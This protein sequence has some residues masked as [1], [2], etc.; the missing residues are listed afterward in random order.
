MF[1]AAAFNI[2][3]NSGKLVQMLPSLPLLIVGDIHGDIIS[4]F[5]VLRKYIA[6]LRKNPQTVLVFL[7]DYVDRG[8]ASIDILIILCLIKSKFPSRIYLCRGNHETVNIH[9]SNTND[10]IVYDMVDR[11]TTKA[12]KTFIAFAA[13]V[14]SL[15]FVFKTD[16]VICMHGGIDK[17][18]FESPVT[19]LDTVYL[20]FSPTTW[21]PHGL[22]QDEY[23]CLLW[24][25]YPDI[26]R[27]DKCPSL[28][29]K[30][31]DEMMLTN[32]LKI[33]ARGHSHTLAG[34]KLHNNAKDL[35]VLISSL[36]I[37]RIYIEEHA[38]RY[39]EEYSKLYNATIIKQDKAS[40][41]DDYKAATT[42]LYINPSSKEQNVIHVYDDSL[43]K[44]KESLV[45]LLQDIQDFYSAYKI[46]NKITRFN[47]QNNQWKTHAI[48]TETLESMGFK[49]PEN[50]SLKENNNNCRTLDELFRILNKL[51]GTNESPYT[52]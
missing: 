22:Y 6:L 36:Y 14:V 10:P 4:L 52:P 11:Y 43:F 5:I 42:I 32:N 26:R 9:Q 29:P 46:P 39:K 47:R 21:A 7:G 12:T 34:C 48:I 2:I 51:Q 44:N 27:T 16:E 37:T 45:S 23:D 30:E 19:L 8:L 31:M 25:G 1:K 41:R 33:F 13:F 18:L 15:S 50:L 40:E 17:G 35:Y 20:D 38:E 3:S 24:A 28:G 49:I